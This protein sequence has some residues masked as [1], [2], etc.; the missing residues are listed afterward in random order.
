M[1]NSSEVVGEAFFL[2]FAAL[3]DV[4]LVQPYLVVPVLV[5]S[6]FHLVKGA[7]I[8]FLNLCTIYASDRKKSNYDFQ[9]Y[10]ILTTESRCPNV[11]AH[12]G[13]VCGRGGGHSSF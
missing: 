10:N 8:L 9:R 6:A 4:A 7:V 11:D 3:V 2:V 5:R 12:L 13:C 1:G